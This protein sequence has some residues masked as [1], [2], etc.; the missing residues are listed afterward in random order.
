M[1]ARK[2]VAEPNHFTT[3]PTQ[4]AGSPTLKPRRSNIY[5]RPEQTRTLSTKAASPRF[6]EQFELARL[7]PFVPCWMVVQIH[8]LRTGQD[9]HRFTS[10][11]LQ[12]A[13]AEAVPNL[14]ASSKRS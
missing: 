2:I 7:P 4:I 10:P 6:T 5:C 8:R 12:P 13:A 14:P 3:R 9:R 1:S 11:R